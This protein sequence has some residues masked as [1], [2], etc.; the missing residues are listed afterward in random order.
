MPR[1]ASVETTCPL[2]GKKF[3]YIPYKKRTTCSLICKVRYAASFT[4]H[5]DGNSIHVRFPS[6]RAA[7]WNMLGRC[8]GGPKRCPKHWHRYGGRGITVCDKW[9]K[10]GFARFLEDM[11]PKPSPSLTLERRNNNGNY[12]P[13]NCYWA[14]WEDQYNNRTNKGKGNK[15]MDKPVTT[16]VPPELWRA[17]KKE[18]RAQKVKLYYVFEDALRLWLDHQKERRAA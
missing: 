3:T 16:R 13:S 14:T 10:G 4:K 11:G 15:N 1:L 5:G 2:C 8:Y 17:V 18:A 7:Y 9:R 12:E 6:E